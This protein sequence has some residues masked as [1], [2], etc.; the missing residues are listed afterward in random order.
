MALISLW[1]FF[2]FLNLNGKP[3]KN[4]TPPV[5][6]TGQVR[7]QLEACGKCGVQRFRT[8]NCILINFINFINLIVVLVFL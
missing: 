5:L 7:I 3:K 6:I 2:F 4:H 8:F 1:Y